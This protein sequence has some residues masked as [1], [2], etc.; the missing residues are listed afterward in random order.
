MVV[1]F[2]VAVSP[3]DGLTEAVRVWVPVNPLTGAIVMVEVA[4]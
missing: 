2:R 4:V 1:G 3:V